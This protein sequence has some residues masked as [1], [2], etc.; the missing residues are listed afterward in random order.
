MT[1]SVGTPRTTPPA[2][3][4]RPWTVR[5]RRRVPVALFA[6]LLVAVGCKSK[7]VGGGSG[8]NEPLPD[9]LVHGPGRIPKQNLPVPDRGTTGPKGRPDP[10]LGEPTG[11]PG[12]RTGAGYTDDPARWKNGPYTPDKA[13]TPAA[14]AGRPKDDGEG[15]RIDAPGGVKLTPAGGAFAPADSAVASDPLY[16]ELGRYG[17]KRGD[18]TIARESG[19]VV[20]RVKVPIS[21]SGATRGYAGVGPTETEA[22]KQVLAQVAADRK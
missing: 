1:A 5:V 14:L 18:Y 10:L 4:G 13:A 15:L 20:V 12:A 11:R 7:E 2:R 6:A 21:G 9:P 8:G 17:V 3:F 22:V 16:A 19:Q